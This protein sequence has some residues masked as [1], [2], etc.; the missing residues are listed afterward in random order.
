MVLPRSIVHC[1][2]AIYMTRLFGHPVIIVIQRQSC[3]SNLELAQN[4]LRVFLI[5]C[6]L[7]FPLQEECQRVC[8]K[9]AKNWDKK[10]S[11]NRKIFLSVCLRAAVSF[12]PLTV[13][14][15]SKMRF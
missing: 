14:F 13:L 8:Q 12:G 11:K 2:K 3:K 15:V 1:Y 10:S 6:L 5:S 7:L 9:C 4:T